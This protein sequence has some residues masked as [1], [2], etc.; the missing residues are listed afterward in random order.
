MFSA[1]VS[2]DSLKYGS[3]GIWDILPPYF[4]E[5]QETMAENTNALTNFLNSENVV[6]G[7]ELYCREKIFIE[8]FNDHCRDNHFATTKWTS[9]FYS[10]P[11]S[12]KGIKVIKNTR[13][14]YP[15]D[16]TGRS[17]IGTFIIGI[18]VVDHSKNDL[19]FDDDSEQNSKC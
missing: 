18:D 9:Q 2:C 1:I 17:T 7:E 3:S 13:R 4:K 14:K 5:S 8:L 16:A 19:L 10:G 15:N 11:F 6:L 12:E